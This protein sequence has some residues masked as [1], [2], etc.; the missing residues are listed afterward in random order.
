MH[1]QHSPFETRPAECARFSANHGQ[2]LSAGQQILVYTGICGQIFSSPRSLTV[3]RM[4]SLPQSFS[5]LISTNHAIFKQPQKTPYGVLQSVPYGPE[6]C[7]QVLIIQ[8]RHSISQT[9]VQDHPDSFVCCVPMSMDRGAH[10]PFPDFCL[11]H[12]TSCRSNLPLVC[13][14][15]QDHWQRRSHLDTPQQEMT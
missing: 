6:T 9:Q 15:A 13:C 14:R 2:D 3:H 7:D 8:Q 5:I 4:R 10:T 1:L 11:H 12:N